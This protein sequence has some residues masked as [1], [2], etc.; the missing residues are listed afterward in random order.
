MEEEEKANVILIGSLVCVNWA[1][2]HLALLIIFQTKEHRTTMTWLQRC[3]I[4]WLIEA[5]PKQFCLQKET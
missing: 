5:P 4:L 2:E 3:I 1:I